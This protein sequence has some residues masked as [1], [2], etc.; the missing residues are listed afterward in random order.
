MDPLLTDDGRPYAPVRFK[1]I[2]RERYEIS[3]R[4]H[5][6]YNEVGEITPTERGYLIDFIL[7]DCKHQK[8]MIEKAREQTKL[9]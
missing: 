1:E 3:K 8:E 2:V 6:S 7:E 5:T 4:L 9:K